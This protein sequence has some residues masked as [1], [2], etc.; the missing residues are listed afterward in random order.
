MVLIF[1]NSAR[2][3]LFGLA[4]HASRKVSFFNHS[5]DSCASSCN[6][7]EFQLVSSHNLWNFEI[8]E[9][10]VTHKK[11]NIKSTQTFRNMASSPIKCQSKN[12]DAQA[13]GS[14]EAIN[15]VMEV[16]E[17]P[18]NNV[19]IS[20]NICNEILKCPVCLTIPRIGPIYQCAN[21]HIVCKDCHSKLVA[22]PVCRNTTVGIRSL[23]SEWILERFPIAC[24]FKNYGCKRDFMKNLLD[25]HEKECEFRLVNCFVCSQDRVV[26][27]FANHVT[28]CH[29]EIQNS[30][31][32]LTHQLAFPHSTNDLL[33]TFNPK[34]FGLKKYDS[35]NLE[36]MGTRFQFDGRFFYMQLCVKEVP[37]EIQVWVCPRMYFDF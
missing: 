4:F 34:M 31:K 18:Q 10:I 13:P 12:N 30:L 37:N 17:S 28:A 27:E 14:Q 25:I 5:T 32:I 21:G 9:E 1:D 20:K 26:S 8:P 36:M 23:A 11:T 15:K 22:C 6:I 29:D 16:E 33:C 2:S 35:M 24:A 3:T 19:S 7:D